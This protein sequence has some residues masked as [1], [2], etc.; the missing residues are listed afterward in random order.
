MI[1][2]FIISEYSIEKRMEKYK[3]EKQINVCTYLFERWTIS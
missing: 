1:G 2:I 3:N